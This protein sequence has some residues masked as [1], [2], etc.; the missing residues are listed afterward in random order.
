[1][2]LVVQL[3]RC[4]GILKTHL[5]HPSGIGWKERVH[6]SHTC[7]YVRPLCMRDPMLLRRQPEMGFCQP[8]VT[9]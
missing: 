6:S 3:S 2:G 9:P 5:G 7:E 4:C 1:M 8:Y